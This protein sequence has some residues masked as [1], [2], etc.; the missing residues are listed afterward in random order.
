MSKRRKKTHECPGMAITYNDDKTATIEMNRCPKE[1]IDELNED[2]ARTATAPAT[3][4]L[5]YINY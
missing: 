1:S 3:K 2:M 4:I 5:F